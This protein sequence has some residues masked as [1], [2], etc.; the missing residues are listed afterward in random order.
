MQPF[1]VPA[2]RPQSRLHA[3]R[4]SRHW[5]PCE[6]ADWFRAAETNS[7]VWSNAIFTWLGTCQVRLGYPGKLHSGKPPA[8]SNHGQLLTFLKQESLITSGATRSVCSR[9]VYEMRCNKWQ[10]HTFW[11]YQRALN[12]SVTFRFK[13]FGF[14]DLLMGLIYKGN[15]NF[16]VKGVN[17]N[18]LHHEQLHIA[19]GFCKWCSFCL[20]HF[21]M[22][23]IF[24]P[25]K[26]LDVKIGN[27]WNMLLS[28][29][30]CKVLCV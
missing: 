7:T 30:R 12:V 5:P 2:N 28:D 9:K 15:Y 23:S 6:W 29:N 21:F 22:S 25:L 1:I 27:S 8:C 17:S 16:T 24:P 10:P 13:L 3:A 11:Q 18:I 19:V 20:L 14:P 4:W 26:Y